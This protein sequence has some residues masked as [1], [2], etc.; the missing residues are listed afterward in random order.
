MPVKIVGCVFCSMTGT[1]STVNQHLRGFHQTDKQGRKARLRDFHHV[2]IIRA[3][4]HLITYQADLVN[5]VSP[6]RL[7]V[8]K[9]F[10]SFGTK[11]FLTHDAVDAWAKRNY[12]RHHLIWWEAEVVAAIRVFAAAGNNM[13]VLEAHVKQ[14][15]LK[16]GR[17]T[18][19]RATHRARHLVDENLKEIRIPV[20]ARV[21]TVSAA[22]GTSLTMQGDRSQHEIRTN[23]SLNSQAGDNRYM[24]IADD[25]DD[26]SLY[27]PPRGLQV[28][29]HT[30]RTPGSHN[31]SATDATRSETRL[32]VKSDSTGPS[33]TIT[34]TTVDEDPAG[35]VARPTT[36]VVEPYPFLIMNITGIDNR[37]KRYVIAY[38]T[39]LTEALAQASPP[40]IRESNCPVHFE[41]LPGTEWG[42]GWPECRWKQV[43]EAGEDNL[44]TVNVRLLFD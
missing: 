41:G 5:D 23:A 33:F 1:V 2:Q 28:A 31:F 27:A 14:V 43:M 3:F 8:L 11:Q 15:I 42:G 26:V 18:L 37:I 9:V 7:A 35:P 30:N 10:A 22:G 29:K 36:A 34:R 39:T 20:G 24:D 32:P 44:L 19:P 17:D 4:E 16:A 25:T 12:D 40:W 13:D 6:Q 38:G 21:V